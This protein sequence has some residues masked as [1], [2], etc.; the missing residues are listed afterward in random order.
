MYWPELYLYNFA[1]WAHDPKG[2]ETI[3]YYIMYTMI[4]YMERLSNT[5]YFSFSQILLQIYDCI[6][7]CWNKSYIK[8][9]KEMFYGH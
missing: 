4:K 8:Y 5:Q 9:Y 1:K 7:A 3:V 2:P 6:C